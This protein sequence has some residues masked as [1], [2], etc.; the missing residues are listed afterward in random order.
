MDVAAKVHVHAGLDLRGARV[1]K[2]L[3]CLASLKSCVA[4]W[5][6]AILSKASVCLGY[7]AISS[8]LQRP[9]DGPARVRRAHHPSPLQALRDVWQ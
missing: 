8:R 9:A 6:L 4:A 3:D 2:S 7:R 1:F 5:F